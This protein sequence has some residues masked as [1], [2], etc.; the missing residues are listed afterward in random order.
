MNTVV[1][2]SKYVNNQIKIHGVE[3]LDYGHIVDW[4][5]ENVE[6]GA[7]WRFRAYDSFIFKYE[8]DALAFKLRFGL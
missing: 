2:I 6:L 7:W 5:Y 3:H 1:N 8:E 4:I